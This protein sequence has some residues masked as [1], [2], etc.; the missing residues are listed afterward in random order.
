MYHNTAYNFIKVII[1]FS[2]KVAFALIII[3][4]LHLF[5]FNTS[6]FLILNCLVILLIIIFVLID[7]YIP[8]Q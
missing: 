7:L 2:F 6:H 1:D 8:F 3:T 4:M 5:W